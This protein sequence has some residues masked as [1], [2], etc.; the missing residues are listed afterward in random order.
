MTRYVY[1]NL[2]KI[3]VSVILVF[4]LIPSLVFFSSVWF[5]SKEI[6]ILSLIISVLCVIFWIVCIISVS[7]LNKYSSNKI[8]FQ[9]NQIIYN[10]RTFYKE[11]LIFKYFKFHI[12]VLEPNLV[13]PSLHIGGSNLSLKCYLSKKDIKKLESMNYQIRKI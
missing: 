12:S 6:H 1:S 9:E 5:E 11:N 8:S 7:A 2:I 13:I 4:I 3:I 10:G